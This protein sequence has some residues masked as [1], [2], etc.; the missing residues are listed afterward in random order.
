MTRALQKL[1]HAGCRELGIDADTRRALQLQATGKASMAEMTEA[2][3]R[4]VADR[5]KARGFDPARSGRRRH[6]PAPRADL[7][8]V[9]ALWGVLGRAGKLDNPTRAGLNAFVRRR[10][11]NAWGSVPADVDMLRDHRQI[12]DLIQALRAWCDREGVPFR[13]KA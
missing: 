9:H 6:A 11:G 2:D 1:I 3:L 7:R 8:L 10:F 4:L 12:D 13:G 5:L